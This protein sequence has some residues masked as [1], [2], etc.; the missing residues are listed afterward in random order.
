MRQ[1]LSDMLYPGLALAE[2]PTGL[3]AGYVPGMDVN[4]ETVTCLRSVLMK[5]EQEDWVAEITARLERSAR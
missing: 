3:V 2:F 5:P 4:S 1:F